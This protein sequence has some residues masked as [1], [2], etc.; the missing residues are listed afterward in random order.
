M[1]SLSHR[2][3]CVTDL[4]H[5]L[6]FYCE[7]LDFVPT[8]RLEG[9]EGPWLD[10]ANGLTESRIDVAGVCNAQGIA[11]NFITFARPGPIGTRKRRQMFEIGPTHINFYVRDLDATLARVLVAGG[12]V[13]EHTRVDAED[14]SMLFCTDPDGIRVEIWTSEPY[15]AGGMA[16][17]VPGVEVKFSHSGICVSEIQRSL[18]F[19][20][21]LGFVAAERFDYRSPPGQ[22]DRMSECEG[23]ALLAQMLRMNEDVV[24]LL[25]FDHPPLIGDG[26]PRPANQLG[27]VNLAF[28][29]ASIDAILP[30]LMAAGGRVDR[31]SRSSWGA[32]E[33]IQ[34]LDPDGV[35]IE[36]I[37]ALAP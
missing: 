3:L 36:L 32:E 6:R 9:L 20:E 11:L 31:E 16:T 34:C 37:A 10:R 22:L 35:R 30:D 25:Q 5:S 21:A 8:H 13:L 15:N 33:Q 19:Y 24:E 1:T 17:A 29:V 7:A 27:L 4:D 2:G 26:N 23:S 14:V 12:T 18:P 28:R